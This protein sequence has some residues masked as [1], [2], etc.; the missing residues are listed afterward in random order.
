MSLN[1]ANAEVEVRERRLHSIVSYHGTAVDLNERSKTKSLPCGGLS[2]EQCKDCSQGCAESITYL[3]RDAAVVVHSP[4]GCCSR[5]AS[6]FIQGDV[7]NRARGLPAQNVN[8][9]C[10]N[11]QEKD[12]IYG[13]LEKLRNA[14]HEAYGRF[15]PSAIF[16]HSSCAAG[17]VGDDI[18]SEADALQDELGIPV[19]PIF[20]EGFKSR[21]WSTGFDAGFHGILR[22]IVKP[23]RKKDENLIN[24]FN[25]EGSDT[26]GPLL[27]K[28][29]LRANYLVP[30]ATVETLSRMSEAACSA[31]ICE[32]LATYV[33]HALEEKYGVPEVKAP[34]PFGIEWTDQWLREIAKY[35][36]KEE[37][38]EKAIASEHQRILPELQKIRQKLAGKNV[39]VFAGDSFAH[40]IANMANDLNLK[41]LGVTTLHHDQATDGNLESLNTLDQYIKSRGDIGFF[42]VCNKQPYQMVKILKKLHPDLLIVRHANMT[43]LGTK[44]GIPTVLE[45]DVNI[46]AGY[47]GVIKLG[48]RL[49]EA[50]LTRKAIQ[51]ISEHVEWPYTD[52]WLNEENPFYFEGGKEA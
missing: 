11:I 17:I 51:T 38:A 46:N 3:I 30:L 28:I 25:F 7:V 39:Y 29:G 1:L 9:I 36:H 32:T 16:V 20:C 43:I 14:V 18:D 48:K 35:T 24:I 21:I 15:H 6:Y 12:T 19:V 22:K 34:A 44:L 40:S 41:L 13:G 23:P 10:S 47:D 2:Y 4:V 33:A 27:E 50:L 26:F 45:G 8:I 31:H 52:W 42:T 5:G 49:Y 37:L